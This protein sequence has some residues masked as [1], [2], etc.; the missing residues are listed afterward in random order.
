MERSAT[1]CCYLVVMDT[2]RGYS[3]VGDV[4]CIV[5]EPISPL[6]LETATSICVIIITLHYLKKLQ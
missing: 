6:P 1:E 5:N 3:V 2:A 4:C